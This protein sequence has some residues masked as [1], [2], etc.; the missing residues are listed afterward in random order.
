[1]AL[2][3]HWTFPVAR[4]LCIVCL[5]RVVRYYRISADRCARTARVQCG[6]QSRLLV[7]QLIMSADYDRATILI[8]IRAGK[9]PEPSKNEPNPGFAKNRTEQNRNPN[10][11]VLTRFLH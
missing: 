9:V 6:R 7:N 10:V 1:M 5:L 11:V 8:I 4:R 3:T 2:Q